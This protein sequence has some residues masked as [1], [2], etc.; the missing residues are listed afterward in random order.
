MEKTMLKKLSALTIGLC[1][2]VFLSI[3]SSAY[4]N[5]SWSTDIDLEITAWTITLFAPTT[6]LFPSTFVKNYTWESIIDV[7]SLTSALVVTWSN[8]TWAYFW[9]EDLEWSASGYI[10]QLQNDDLVLDTDP[11]VVIAKNNIKLTM[12]WARWNVSWTW[13]D[14]LFILDWDWYDYETTWSWVPTPAQILTFPWDEI[15][16]DTSAATLFS[17]TWATTPAAWRLWM[18][19]IQPIFKIYIPK[20]QQLGNYT[21]T[22]TLTYTQQ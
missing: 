18:F 9:L 17:R 10:L 12:S 3:G 7:A 8:L 20:Y 2:M 16:F 13:Q 22:F 21:T 6:I 19:W 11:W 15:P 5:S 14:W 4:A 1:A